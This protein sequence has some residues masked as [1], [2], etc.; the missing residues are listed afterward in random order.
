MR[1]NVVD[2]TARWFI[3]ASLQV[4]PGTGF[5]DSSWERST[6]VSP[7]RGRRLPPQ[8]SVSL[9][10]EIVFPDVPNRYRWVEESGTARTSAVR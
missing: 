10:T 5:A 4:N 1:T 7:A 6:P 3:T 8:R 9:R 2:A